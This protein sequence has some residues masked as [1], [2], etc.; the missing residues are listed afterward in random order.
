M[1]PPF[2]ESHGGY[3][4][5]RPAEMAN[6]RALTASDHR[7]SRVVLVPPL[8]F[9]HNELIQEVGR[10]VNRMSPTVKTRTV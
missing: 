4:F 9:F 3:G 1:V 5:P 7:L 10:G 2:S 8:A 6:P